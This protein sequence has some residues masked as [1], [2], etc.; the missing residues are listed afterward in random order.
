MERGRKRDG[1]V[2]EGSL[3]FVHEKLELKPD[4]E[5]E[6]E[7]LVV[8]DTVGIKIKL[9]LWSQDRDCEYSRNFPEV[10]Q[11]LRSPF[12]CRGQARGAYP[13]PLEL[14]DSFFASAHGGQRRKVLLY[15]LSCAAQCF[16]KPHFHFSYFQVPKQTIKYLIKSISWPPPQRK[17][18]EL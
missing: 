7:H 15:N 16:D 14:L 13:E 18:V 17:Q 9:A 12:H 4:E 6:Q 8:T 1:S 3:Y 10:H 2:W 5:L 11:V